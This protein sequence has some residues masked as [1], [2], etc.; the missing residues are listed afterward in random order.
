MDNEELWQNALAEIELE[1]S[2]P[3][4][5]TWFQ[6]TS[7]INQ[8]NGVVILSVP[9]NF[10][11]EWLE[12]KYHKFILKTLRNLS[13]N[14]RN[15]QYTISS[16]PLRIETRRPL[17]IKQKPIPANEEQLEFT[18][19]YT[20]K[21]DNLNPRYTF[22]T[23]IVGS[24]NELAHAAALAITNNI[25]TLYNPFLVYGGVGLGKTHLIQAI[26]NK[27]KSEYKN[28]KITYLT[29]E[30][31][32][33]EFVEAMQNKNIPSFKEKYR[34]HDVLIIDD[35]QFFGGKGKIQEEFFLVFNT[36]YENGKQ[37]IF[38]SDRP[39]RAIPDLE[40]RLRSRFEG[41]MMADILRPGYEERLAILKSKAEVRNFSLHQSILEYIA[42]SI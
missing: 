25:G 39:P 15:V 31:F 6:H 30:K 23:F 37:I 24:F 7:I 5:A 4:F 13:P 26:G 35:V 10:V 16:Q 36:L 38:S 8:D 18:E 2:K 41:G 9:N 12:N 3:S 34:K 29:S 19:I 17:K 21:E 28:L 33:N 27:I 11:K 20:N 1:I 32:T 40:E 22:D 42:S 14:I